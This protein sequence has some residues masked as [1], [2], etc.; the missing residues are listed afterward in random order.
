MRRNS[1]TPSLGRIAEQAGVSRAAVSMALRNHPR[2]PSSTRERIQGIAKE[3]G[4]KPNP[5]L[6]EAMSA[7][8]AGQPPTDRVTLAWIT[9]GAQRDDWKS[10]Y[11]DVRCHAGAVERA[12]NA[13]YRLETFWLGDANN[14]PDR[15]G[16]ILYNRGINGILVAPLREPGNL[17]LPWERFAAATIAHTLIS[18]RLHSANDNHVAAV[19]VCV[20]RMHARNRRRIGLALSAKLDHRVADLWSA[21]YL[22]ET[23]EEGLADPK[24]LHRPEDRVDEVNFIRWVKKAKPDAIIGTHHKIPEWLEKAGYK[25]PKDIAYAGVDLRS[26]DGKVAGIFQDARAIGAGAIDM[27][28]GQLLRHER[29][30]PDKPKTSIID[31]HWID[32]ATLPEK[33][34]DQSL[35]ARAERLLNNTGDPEPARPVVYD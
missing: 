10:S 18:P 8:R 34:H 32:G 5:L 27:I 3:M 19:R 21:G 25:V 20:A 33:I 29:G 26:N 22:L 12:E 30:I 9:T 13:G 1:N 31:G 28:A 23:F 16:N 17:P 11:F 14:N 6:A 4:W 15:M 2:I 24:L 7:I 35:I